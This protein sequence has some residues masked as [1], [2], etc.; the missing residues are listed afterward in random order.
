MSKN[1]ILD[2]LH[3]TREKLLA[4]SGG[5][6]SGLMDR[7][8][9]EQAASGRPVYNPGK[10]MPVKQNGVSEELPAVK[11]AAPASDK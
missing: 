1:P 7:L 3:A 2:E 8:R 6:I 5:S 9:A 4:E 10:D 11:E